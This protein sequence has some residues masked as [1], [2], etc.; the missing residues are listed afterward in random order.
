MQLAQLNI[1]KAL[2]PLDAPEISEFMDNLD[3]INGI[4]EQS[5]GFVWRLKDDS[6][7]A[8]SI[9]AYDDPLM[10]VN[11][12]VW[13]SI[14][15]LK[16]FMFRSKHKDFLQ[17]RALWFE[18]TQ[19]SA[20]VMWWVQDGHTPTVEEAKARLAHLHAFGESNKA[21]TMA[22]RFAPEVLFL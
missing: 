13:E 11:M 15:A 5:P 22:G 17:K 9:Q 19:Q 6:G 21:F 20:Y 10:L 14:D 12:S 18:K 2:Y 1:G 7:D 3:L 16:D 8:T 4:A